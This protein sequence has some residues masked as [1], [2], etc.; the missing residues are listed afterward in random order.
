MR[1]KTPRPPLWSRLPPGVRALLVWG[2]VAAL[3]PLLYAMTLTDG[4]DLLPVGSAHAGFAVAMAVPLAWA[5]QRP[6]LVLAVLLAEIV[7]A[8]ALG[9]PA[10]GAWPLFP[11]A[12]VLVCLI[13]A[14]QSRRAG[15]AAAVAALLVQQ[16]AWQLDLLRDGLRASAPGF[17][18]L[19]LLLG[20]AVLVAWLAGMFLRQRR[21]YDRAL[22]A[23]AEARAV[24][25][26][27]LR[28][29][30]ELHD[31]VA[32]SIGVI[33]IQAGAGARV[34]DSRPEQA[35]QALGAI[36]ATSRQTLK[37]LR[38]LL[39]VL[40][41][42]EGG[43]PGS[44]ERGRPGTTE[45]G[46]PG[47][48]ERG[49]PGSA[50][51]AAPARLA[52]I[53]RLAQTT[54]AAG[55]RVDVRRHGE[56]RPLPAAVDRSAFRII[57]ESVTNVLRHARTDHCRVVI[58]YGNEE[59]RIDVIDD[60]HAAAREG[61]GHATLCEGDGH[62]IACEGDGRA[63]AS[64]GGGHGIVGMRERVALLNGGFSA[65]PRPEGG[66]RV[67]ARLPLA[68]GGLGQGTDIALVEAQ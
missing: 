38:H 24:T 23:H 16:P 64:E 15:L 66:F 67:T 48:A 43:R 33:A 58:H 20:L 57:Q 22:R 11:A 21:E 56:P 29:A 34:I 45:G 53:D 54:T 61:D 59:L 19:S 10:Q 6:A 9:Y 5:R 14:T 13:A 60:G 8:T 62:G 39:G 51:P 40:R 28:I 17:L 7:A 18:A 12:D 26:E 52:D 31:M 37:G 49:R 1:D 25:D 35:R 36:E 27:R 44:A 41:T 32:H 30:R 42:T 65:G 68:P 63:A 55:V 46:R 2:G 4:E 50:E 3:M 47:W